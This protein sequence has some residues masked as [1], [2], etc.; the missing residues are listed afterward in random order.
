MKLIKDIIEEFKTIL[1]GNT[2]DAVIP[3]A[4][5]L[6]LINQLELI[7]TLIISTIVSIL[8]LINRIYHKDK[9]LYAAIGIIGV[10]VTTLFTYI[11]NNASNFFL[12][13][14]I[15]TSMLIILTL[16]SIIIKR[17]IAA[18][19]SHLT[20]GW[21]LNWFKRNDIRPA[22]MEVSILWLAFFIT[23]LIIEVYL[24]L[25]ATVNELAW[26]NIILG[27]PVTIG[28]L[29]ISYVYGIWRL[30]TL[31]GPGIDEFIENKQPPYKGQTK[32]F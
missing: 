22:Y 12:P 18:Y 9:I 26:A 16:I 14:I 31:K 13:D 29:T 25:S 3:P 1:K 4:V 11:S 2:L 30:R 8:L 32:G 5:F 17:P 20:R 24:Y 23:R 10:I 6:V 15:G 28:V 7:T 27:F 21:D 19:L